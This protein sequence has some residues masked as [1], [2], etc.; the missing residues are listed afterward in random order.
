MLLLIRMV[1]HSKRRQTNTAGFCWF[2]FFVLFYFVWILICFVFVCLF[3]IGPHYVDKKPPLELIELFLPLSLDAG[4]KVGM[5]LTLAFHKL[6]ETRVL[7][8]FRNY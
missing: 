3:E 6:W 7:H 4:V 2:D 5:P 8:S 1:Y